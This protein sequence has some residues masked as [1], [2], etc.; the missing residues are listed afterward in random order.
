MRNPS[1]S[2]K[3]ARV[4]AFSLLAACAA[5]AELK[6]PALFGDHMVLQSGQPVACWGWAN[7]GEKIRVAFTDPAGKQ[8]AQAQ[9]VA[10]NGEGRWSLQLPPLPQGSVGKLTI[11]TDHGETKTIDDVL[12]GE[13]WLA[14]GQ[15]NMTRKVGTADF[16]KEV[17]VLARTE[18]A[19]A[20]GSIRFFTVVQGGA[21]AP[22]NETPG[23]WVVVTPE[24]VVNCSA[25]AWN[26]AAKLNRDLKAPVGIILS[27]YGGTPVESWV[28]EE[29]LDATLASMPVWKRH[30]NLLASYPEAKAK[31]DQTFAAWEATNPTP[32]LQKQNAE[33][34]PRAPYCETD[35]RAPVRLFNGM[36]YG[37]APYTLQGVLWYQGEEN[38]SRSQEYGELIQALIKSWRGFWGTELPF[39]YV[40]LANTHKPQQKP[41][42][43]GWGFIR[44]AQQAALKLPKTAVA[45][46]VDLGNG[47]I[48]PWNK[49][50]V[51]E[52]LAAIALS[53][54]YGKA[55][56]SRSPQFTSFEIQGSVIRVKFDHAEGLRARGDGSVAGFAI[57]G[58]GT[59]WK[60]ADAKIVGESVEV[61]SK[62]IPSPTAVR[63]GWASNPVLSLE[64]QYG[65]PLR[66]FRTDS[67]PR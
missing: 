55:I 25:V 65:L 63:Y 13:V 58:N 28:P 19:E 15:S 21:D 16:P 34:K 57:T 4:A 52:R 39:Y 48:H 29:A 5:Q 51:G 10:A 33:T 45:T 3:L 43:D 41:S 59:D 61:S 54:V 40:E 38:S 30:A 36:I 47:E 44:E 37:L 31:Y 1:P 49:K 8:L 7:P 62:E 42:E 60:W 23:K 17:A 32:E 14:S 22:R 66:P 26:F 6:L 20:R 67:I 12:P 9:A 27:G 56:P 11:Q 2:V 53:D 46:A 50:P 24:T 18:A 35:S 64:N